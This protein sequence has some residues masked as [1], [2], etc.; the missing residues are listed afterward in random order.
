MDPISIYELLI[1]IQHI[2]YAYVS[3][4]NPAFVNPIHLV[5]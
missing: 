4:S 3:I 2:V 1:I 5:L